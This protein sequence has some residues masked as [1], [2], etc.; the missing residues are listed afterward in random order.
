MRER[1][2]P[3]CRWTVVTDQAGRRRLEMRW[4]PLDAAPAHSPVARA[5]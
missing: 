2:C 3:E 1:F 5:A 4:V